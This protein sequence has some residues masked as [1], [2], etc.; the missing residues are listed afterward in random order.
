MKSLKKGLTKANKY[1]II[2]KALNKVLI[3]AG[4]V[5]LADAPDL[6]NVTSLIALTT[7]YKSRLGDLTPCKN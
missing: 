3:S 4:M 1:D 6:G 5:E 7:C 2:I